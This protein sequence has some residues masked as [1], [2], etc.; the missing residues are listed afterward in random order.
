MREVALDETLQVEAGATIGA[1]LAQVAKTV[2][3]TS[4]GIAKTVSESKDA[5]KAASLST[6]SGDTTTHSLPRISLGA[7]GA[8]DLAPSPGTAPPDLRFVKILGEGGMGRVHLASQNSLRREVA[9][10]TLKEDANTH[11]HEALLSEARV[12]GYLSHPGII[13]VHSLG[14]DDHDR[15]VLVMKCIEGVPWSDLLADPENKAWSHWDSRT[16]DRLEVHVQILM[17]ICD[18]LHFAHNQEIIHRDIKPENVMLGLF[19]EVYLVDWGLARSLGSDEANHLVGTPAYMAPEMA[20]GEEVDARTDVYL[21]GATLHEVVTG[22]YLHT[23]KTLHE[24]LKHAAT[25]ASISYAEEVPRE[26]AALCSAAT[27]KAA[28]DRPS[29]AEEFRLALADYLSHRSSIEVS[30]AALLRLEAAEASQSEADMGPQERAYHLGSHCAEARFGFQEALRAW[31]ENLAAERGLQRSLALLVDAHLLRRDPVGAMAQLNAMHEPPDELLPKIQKL[32]IELA[33]EGSDRARLEDLD[34]DLDS[35]TGFK[36]R[37]TAFLLFAAATSTMTIV[38]LVT[39]KGSTLTNAESV[40]AISGL[41]VLALASL[42]FKR[43][44]F[45]ANAFNKRMVAFVMIGMTSI[46]ANRIAGWQLGTSIPHVL[47]GD[48]LLVSV[49][50]AL[51]GYIV[52]AWIKWMTPV[53][54]TGAAIIA[55]VPAAPAPTIFASC[56]LLSLIVGGIAWLAQARR[57]LGN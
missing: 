4:A 51:C 40:L 32:E 44:M 20:L 31:P 39:G 2:S 13:P 25:S 47:V 19:G 49:S 45:F 6:K 24:L 46:L 37:L 26:L 17:K 22:G 23:G 11:A 16:G 41:L 14:L 30:N 43:K 55:F 15:P 18:A 29:S 28:K 33:Q 56:V 36:A 1:S 27:A 53:L 57:D 3:A 21:L 50:S 42:L 12:T 7:L 35:R 10:K 54:L 52:T 8:A 9:V 38:F 34:R 5:E 48:L